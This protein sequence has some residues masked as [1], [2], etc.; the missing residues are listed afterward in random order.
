FFDRPPTIDIGLSFDL[1]QIPRKYYKYLPILPSCFDSLGL[2]EGEH[3]V[4]YSELLTE[5][6]SRFIDFAPGV[7]DNAVSHRADFTFRASATSVPEFRAALQWIERMLRSSYIDLANVDRLRD[8]VAERI[9]TDDSYTKQDEFSWIYNP[10][11]SFRYQ[12]DPLYLA[13]ES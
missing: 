9:S 3:I 13:L 4:P 1:H 5:T 2:K 11:Y 12:H 7:D 10:A 6:K 8:I